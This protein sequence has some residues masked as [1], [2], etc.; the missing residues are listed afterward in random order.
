MVFEQ[1]I[2]AFIICR[3]CI[4]DKFAIIE[5]KTIISKILRDFKLHPVEGKT[6]FE[7]LFRI[8]LRASGG[9]WVKLEPR[10]NNN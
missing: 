4:G 10:N 2:F 6:T 5:M 8:T 9:L 1:L 3:K 7:P